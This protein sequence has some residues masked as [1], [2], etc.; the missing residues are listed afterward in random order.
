MKKYVLLL[1][2]FYIIMGCSKQSTQ[3]IVFLENHTINN[4][5]YSY[6]IEI[7]NHWEDKY[8]YNIKEANMW[9]RYVSNDEQFSPTIFFIYTISDDKT[10]EFESN[11]E[12]EFIK[13]GQRSGVTF[14]SVFPLDFE[15]DSQSEIDEYNSMH[16]EVKHIIETFKFIK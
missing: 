13:L 14:Y 9:F 15:L 12:N 2:S 16:D 1:V 10:E 8:T 4:S 3:E 11:P 6:S 5:E 7:P